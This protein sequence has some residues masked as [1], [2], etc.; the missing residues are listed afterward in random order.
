MIPNFLTLTGKSA[1]LCFY[2]LA[3]FFDI[4]AIKK[5][6]RS[7]FIFPRGGA[8][9]LESQI[10]YVFL[11]CDE[12]GLGQ[13]VARKKYLCLCKWK[14]FCVG[15]NKQRLVF[16]SKFRLL[17]RIA[18]ILPLPQREALIGSFTAT[19]NLITQDLLSASRGIF[20][21]WINGFIENLSAIL[22]ARFYRI[23]FCALKIFCLLI[24]VF[25]GAGGSAFLS[26]MPHGI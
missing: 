23:F 16:Y 14:F 8:C 25:Q 18:E 21:Y 3:L 4:A 17:N 19:G 11:P 24:I 10:F 5:L 15:E 1:L 13:F 6:G 2:P 12:K 22:N 20:F 9:L 7:F 26:S